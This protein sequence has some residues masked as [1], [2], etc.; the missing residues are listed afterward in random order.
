VTPTDLTTTLAAIGWS[1]RELARRLGYASHRSITQWRTVPGDV[2][3]YLRA[4]ADAVQAVPPV[5]RKNISEMPKITVD[6]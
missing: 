5:T 3:T 4:V 1:R 6:V 2:A